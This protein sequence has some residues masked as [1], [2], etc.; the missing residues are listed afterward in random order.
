MKIHLFDDKIKMAEA[1]ARHAADII[2]RTIAERGQARILAATGGSQ[3]E[4]LAD[5]TQSP[6]IDWTNV[7]LF[8]LDE[9]VGI[10]VNH[11]ASFRRYLLDRL[12]GKTGLRNYH[13]LDGEIAP[14]K[15][16]REIGRLLAAAPVDVAFAGIGE[17]GHVAFNDPPAD[18]KTEEPYLIVRLDEG[19]RR[20]QVGE[21]W[22][23]SLAE[24]PER[25]LTISVRQLLKAKAIIVTVPDLRKAKATQRCLEG[26][27]SPDAPASILR[28]HPNTTLYL[29]RDAAALLNPQTITQGAPVT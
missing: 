3:F 7:E 19:C 15:S 18:F 1:S 28:T 16:C 5:L 21:G 26:P 9:Y 13:L 6:G 12:I 29:D 8:H 20:Q 11:P 4:M 17:N 24:V 27:V 23:K 25:A 22:F 2:R 10:S 14:E